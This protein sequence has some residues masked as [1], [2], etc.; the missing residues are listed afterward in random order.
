MTAEEMKARGRERLMYWCDHLKRMV[1]LNAP[2]AVIAQATFCLFL[3]AFGHHTKHMAEEFARFMAAKGRDYV[4]NREAGS[5]SARAIVGEG[6]K[7]AP[8]GRGARRDR[9]ACRPGADGVGAV[10]RTARGGEADEAEW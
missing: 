4:T 8:P 9:K 3:C 5:D 2:S 7:G 10:R 1:S 6:P